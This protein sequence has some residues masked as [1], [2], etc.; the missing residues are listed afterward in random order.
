[1]LVE[2]IATDSRQVVWAGNGPVLLE[3][4]D[5]NTTVYL[6]TVDGFD[7]SGQDVEIIDPLGSL[8]LDGQSTRWVMTQAGTAIVQVSPGGEG[9]S[10]S[11]EQIALQM[12]TAGLARDSS[13]QGV[14]TTLGTPAQTVDI[15]A[16]HANGKTLAQDMLN[17]GTGVT[18]EIAALIATGLATGAPGGVPL[19]NKTT[20]IG[21]TTINGMAVGGSQILGPF[22][23]SQPGYEVR[24][25]VSTGAAGACYVSYVVDWIDSGTG[26]NLRRNTYTVAAGATGTPHKINGH[27][28][29]KANQIQITVMN[30]AASAGTITTT[31][32]QMQS[33]RIYSRDVWRSLDTQAVGFT[34]SGAIPEAN[35]L[36]NA[37]PNILTGASQVRLLPLYTGR[38]RFSA[39]TASATT[40]AELTL[41]TI[42]GTLA[43]SQTIG[44]IR[45]DAFGHID[46]DLLLPRNQC[47][48][49]LINH[50]AASKV[51]SVVGLTDELET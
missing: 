10:P 36:L 5:I 29:T 39:Q 24:I 49:T 37:A 32:T 42:G 31:V 41:Q 9:W 3:N 28:P 13:V 35:I 7:P 15:G 2:A 1:M 12:I 17:G 48:V 47:T 22:A 8:A 20:L 40:D 4:R 38:V 19:L 30:L 50:N 51:V 26:Q 16:L 25:D 18:T 45:S 6:G 21:Q 34:I 14:K 44:D 46:V 33:S 27:G 11:P 43:N 23:I